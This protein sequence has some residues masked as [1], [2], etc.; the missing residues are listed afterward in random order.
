MKYVITESQK[1]TMSDRIY[2]YIDN[3]IPSNM[4]VVYAYDS[5]EVVDYDHNYDTI[6]KIDSIS[7][8]NN[9]YYDIQMM[10]YLENYWSYTDSGKIKKNDSPML[11]IGSR[12][13]G[14]LDNMF[15]NHWQEPFLR[16]FYH[17]YGHELPDG[18][19]IKTIVSY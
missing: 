5:E 15:G 11:D 6:D 1:Q 7:F 19:K 14:E 13:K 2:K 17:N 10:I 9:H 12:I 3:L 4:T 16:W 8:L 18:V